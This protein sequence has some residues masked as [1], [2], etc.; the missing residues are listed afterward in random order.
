MA[1]LSHNTEMAGPRVM[2]TVCA[3]APET[4]VRP[5][6]GW[7]ELPVWAACAGRAAMREQAEVQVQVT[8]EQ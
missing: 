3:T 7:Q 6:Q 8:G 5:R 4:P 1:Q 2:F